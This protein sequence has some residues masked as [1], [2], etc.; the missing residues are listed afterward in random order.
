MHTS[1]GPTPKG[2]GREGEGKR[3]INSF[4]SRHVYRLTW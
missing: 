3:I 2:G 4:I 1:E